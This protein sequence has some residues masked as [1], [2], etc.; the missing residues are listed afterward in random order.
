MREEAHTSMETDW[1]DSTNRSVV[2]THEDP[3]RF[4]EED[5]ATLF[6][7]RVSLDA[8]ETWMTDPEDDLHF[9]SLD[10]DPILQQPE[11]SWPTNI[12]DD[13]VMMEEE[14]KS[15]IREQFETRRAQLAASMR[16]SQLSRQCLFIQEKIQT[17]EQLSQVL[18]DIEKSSKALNEL[19]ESRNDEETDV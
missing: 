12:E 15:A 8:T 1:F 11:V 14:N 6:P 4:L 7:K 5:E 3:W 19:L 18:K 2:L 17:R 16:A 9:M 13:T 10:H